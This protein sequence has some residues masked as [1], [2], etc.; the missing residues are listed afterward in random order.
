MNYA[1]GCEGKKTDGQYVSSEPFGLW[2]SEE[3]VVE[4]RSIYL[5]QLAARLGPAAV[6]NVTV[7]AQ[8]QGRIW[9]ALA[10]WAGEG[11]LASHL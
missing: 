4:P 1:V 8:R 3:K 9:S 5:A 6:Q 2:L 7:A 11:P 10:A